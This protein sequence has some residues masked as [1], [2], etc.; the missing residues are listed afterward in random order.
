MKKL[1]TKSTK[2][3]EFSTMV[4]TIILAQGLSTRTLDRKFGI[5]EEAFYDSKENRE[6]TLSAPIIYK[7]DSTFIRKVAGAKSN[8]RVYVVRQIHS[9]R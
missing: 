1:H 4:E 8:E 7:C 3:N 9:E 6:L 5:R 2:I